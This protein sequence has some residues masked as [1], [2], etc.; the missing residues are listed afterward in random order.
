MTNE[1]KVPSRRFEIFAM[2][3]GFIVVGIVIGIPLFEYILSGT[4]DPRG[5]S[6][7][8]LY[9]AA[10][11]I[12]GACIIVFANEVLWKRYPRAPKYAAV[13]CGVTFISALP[14]KAHFEP[15]API[16]FVTLGYA[17]IVGIACC[18]LFAVLSAIFRRT[19]S[20]SRS[21]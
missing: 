13:F 5:L 11:A 19:R 2:I 3:C 1:Q 21:H 6:V 16:T 14:V 9:S 15:N 12:I 18:I 20:A 10:T 7:V 17:A 4:L 8:L